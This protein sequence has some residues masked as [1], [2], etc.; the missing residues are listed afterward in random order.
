M[1][2]RFDALQARAKAQWQALAESPRPRV[3]V[4][5]ATQHVN[6]S[7]YVALL[8]HGGELRYY[9]YWIQASVLGQGHRYGFKGAREGLNGPLL[10]ARKALGPI[11]EPHGQ[12]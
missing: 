10:L 11:T 1:T 2:E 5:T 9:V 7:P 8:V 6:A 4:G 3:L 12:L